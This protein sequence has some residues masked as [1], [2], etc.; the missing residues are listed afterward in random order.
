MPRKR[1]SDDYFPC[2]HCGARVRAGARFCRECGASD[3]SG[4]GEDQWSHDADGYAEDED[5]DYDEYLRREF[6]EHAPPRS[7]KA[8]SKRLL[9]IL[10]VA[11]VC[12]ALLLWA[13]FSLP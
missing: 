7:A 2:P 3:E 13:M 9:T 4:W 10:V 11:L 12:L 1:H 8:Q 6:P 5:F